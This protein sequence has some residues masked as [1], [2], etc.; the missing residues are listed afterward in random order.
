M[1]Q[2]GSALDAAHERGLIHRDVKPANILIEANGHVYLTDFGIAKHTRTRGGL[3]KTGSFLGTLDYAAPEQIEGKQVDGRVDVYAL[4]CVLYQC[5]TGAA[6]YDKESE[7]Q[8]IYAHLLERATPVT[9]RH[10][11]LPPALDAVLDKALAKARDARYATCRDLVSDLRS[12]LSRDGASAGRTMQA[13]APT[14]AAAAPPQPVPPP[15]A[16]PPAPPAP[17]AVERPPQ[18]VWRRLPVLIGAAVGVVVAVVVAVVVVASGSGG[19]SKGSALTR[20]RG[21]VPTAIRSTCSSFATTGGASAAVSCTAGPQDVTYFAFPS[22]AA[23][24][25]FYKTK[26]PATFRPNR[27]SCS[28]LPRVGERPYAA[29]GKA[30]GRVF[31]SLDATGG[32]SIGWTNGRA[33]TYAQA[34]RTDGNQKALYRWWARAAGPLSAGAKRVAVKTTSVPSGALLFQDTFSNR[35][36]GWPQVN[37]KQLRMRY[38]S[39]AYRV[40]VRPANQARLRS[41]AGLQPAVLFADTS[42]GVDATRIS[43]PGSYSFGLVCRASSSGSYRLE[44]RSDGV[45]V[46]ARSFGSS[47]KVLAAKKFGAGVL[48]RTN[49]VRASCVGGHGGPVRLTLALNGRTLRATDKHPLAATGGVGMDAVTGSRGKAE[50]RFDNFTVRKP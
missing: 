11:G 20:L 9:K 7:V 37:T 40:F 46:I 1:E 2:V 48:R 3:T 47:A 5:L 39:G 22:A 50:I 18:P 43:S 32:A 23:A 25:R 26:L 45:F 15:V 35:A 29:G 17:P 16:P 4:G 28:G 19:G 42:L 13:P 34:S 27:G 30:A 36:T 33:K 24:D 8:L 31:C 44:I 49:H 14:R 10:P 6:P 41:T 38:F 12:A 21:L